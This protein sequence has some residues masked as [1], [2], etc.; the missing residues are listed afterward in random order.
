MADH[1]QRFKVALRE[2]FPEFFQLFFPQ[3]ADRFDFCG[4]EWLDK[5]VFPDPP[6]GERQEMD[7]VAKVPV[8]QAVERPR[9]AEGNSW[10]VLVHVEVESR[11]SVAPLRGRMHAYY[12]HLKSRYDLPVLPIGL[13]L[14]VGLEGVG[15]D[16]Y[17]EWFWE[18]RILHFEYASIGLPAL[19]ALQYLHGTSVFGVALAALMRVPEERRAELKAEA[20]QRVV[21]S[22][23]SKYQQFLLWEIVDTYLSLEGPHFAEYEQL[24]LTPRYKEAREMTLTTYERGEQKGI[25][26]GIEKGQR[27]LVLRQLEQR[28]GSL[29]AVARQRL[30][31][32]PADRL[33]ELGS[34]LLTA[35]SLQELGLEDT[36]SQT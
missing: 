16:V 31:T 25:E 5:E 23:L 14:R 15:W 17:E 10:I 30:E 22:Q 32:W 36:P 35:S 11:D 4:V 8:R 26:K 21:T 7:L 20:A 12:Q 6:R 19:D 13:Y 9:P 29:S 27:S 18:H 33:P 34:R 24:L 28:F 1:D 3:W 2:F